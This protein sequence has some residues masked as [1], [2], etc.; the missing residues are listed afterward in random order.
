MEPAMFNV[1]FKWRPCAL[2]ATF[3]W[4]TAAGPVMSAGM[5]EAELKTKKPPVKAW[6]IHRKFTK[7]GLAFKSYVGRIKDGRLVV[8]GLAVPGRYDLKFQMEKGFIEGWD[9]AVPESDY[10]EEQPLSDESRQ[11]VL[12]KMHHNSILAYYDR[13]V[14]LD[15]QGNIQNAAVL[16]AFL[17]KR[18][19]V[20]G[21]YKPGEWTWRVERWHWEDPLEHTWTLNQEQPYY[22]LVRTRFYEKD[23]KA[24]HTT[25]ARHLG[26]IALTDERPS[27][28]LGILLLPAPKPGTH[29][30]GPDGKTTKPIVIKPW[31]PPDPRDDP[32]STEAKSE[33]GD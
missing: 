10:V 14:V 16:V 15:V 32:D 8:E 20:G 21:G 22:A 28:D 24:L 31:Q 26:A 30:I 5:I 7:T 19:F 6:A 23:F 17:R 12:K 2:A 29:A 3:V 33:Q 27:V 18:P 1:K 13:A 4:L 11:T 25:Y 9:A